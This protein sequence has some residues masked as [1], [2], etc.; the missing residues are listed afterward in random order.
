MSAP[1]LDQI[2]IVASDLDATVGF[3]RLLGIDLR[4]PIRTAGGE[5]FHAS[6]APSAGALLEAD[7]PRF[8]RVWNRGWS[9][10]PDVSGRVLIGLRV[11]D[12]AEVDRLAGEAGSA[13]YRV[14]QPPHDAF[15][16]A[17]YAIVE[18]PDGIAVGLMSPAD[19]AHRAPPPS[20]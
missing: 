2:N 4:D 12:R 14:L 15:W 19:E 17:R 5:P 6:S 16:G 8:A 10:E 3:Y 7:S 11:A 1:L 9:D 13:G 18:D 20:F